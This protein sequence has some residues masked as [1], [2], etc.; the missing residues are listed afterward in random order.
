[1]TRVIGMRPRPQQKE[2]ARVVYRL[3]NIMISPEQKDGDQENM[4]RGFLKS[5]T[6]YFKKN[7]PSKRLRKRSR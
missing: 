6:V 5:G 3:R 2:G 4:V 1:M 7:F